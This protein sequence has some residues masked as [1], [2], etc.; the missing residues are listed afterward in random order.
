MTK[1][2]RLWQLWV[3]ARWRCG[4]WSWQGWWCMSSSSTPFLTST[5][6]LPLSMA[7]LPTLQGQCANCQWIVSFTDRGISRMWKPLSILLSLCYLCKFSLLLK[8]IP[9]FHVITFPWLRVAQPWFY[10]Q[11]AVSSIP[12]K[13]IGMMFRFITVLYCYGFPFLDASLP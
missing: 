5:S 9:L 3:R 4:R 8:G 10:E 13:N 12:V 6:P 7:W 1:K 2:I 11:P